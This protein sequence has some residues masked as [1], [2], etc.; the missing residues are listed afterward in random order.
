MLKSVL[1]YRGEPSPE[2]NPNG[3]RRNQAQKSEWERDAR[4]QVHLRPLKYSYLYDVNRRAM[5]DCTG[6]SSP[7]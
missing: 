2:H 1:V 7:R 3:Y 6:M 4:V 5:A